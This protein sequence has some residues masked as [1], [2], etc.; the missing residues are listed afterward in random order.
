MEHTLPGKQ[1]MKFLKKLTLGKK[2]FIL[3]ALGLV[4][5]IGVLSFL[6]ISAVNQSTE[7]MLEDRLTTARLVAGY[8]DETLDRGNRS[9]PHR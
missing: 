3:L 8:L 5:G 2:I 1:P 4:V 9:Q 6:G 7:V